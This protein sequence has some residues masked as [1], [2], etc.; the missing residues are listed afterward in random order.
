MM[1]SIKS[2]PFV[3]TYFHTFKSKRLKQVKT[4][5]I[6]KP[7]KKS[8]LNGRAIKS[9]GGG[10]GRAIKEKITFFGTFFSTFKRFNGH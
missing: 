2:N 1:S 9:V 4:N 6:G 8:S 10:K 7:Q 3:D 5:L